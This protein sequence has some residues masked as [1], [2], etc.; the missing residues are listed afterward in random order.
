MYRVDQ[1][2]KLVS[3]LN[4]QFSNPILMG[5][6]SLRS[7]VSDSIGHDADASSEEED[8]DILEA[9][10]PVAQNYYGFNNS[11]D[12]SYTKSVSTP[13]SVRKAPPSKQKSS[14]KDGN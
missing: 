7:I 10:T 8:D 12:K 1:W 4:A 3:Q 14:S 5:V 2:S 11:P 9:K 6:Y 13:S